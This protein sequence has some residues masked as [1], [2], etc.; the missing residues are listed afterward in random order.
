M[1]FMGKVKF[2]ETPNMDR[3]VCEGAH[4][5]NAFVTTAPALAQAGRFHP[6]RPALA[7]A[8]LGGQPPYHPAGD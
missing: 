5:Q 3:L 8:W 6:D 1:G 2:L 7:E 4:I